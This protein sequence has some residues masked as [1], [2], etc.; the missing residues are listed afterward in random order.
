[1]EHDALIQEG[2]G[3]ATLRDRVASLHGRMSIDSGIRGS[4]I[5]LAVPFTVS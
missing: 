1:M 2:L 4:R 3:P 5:A